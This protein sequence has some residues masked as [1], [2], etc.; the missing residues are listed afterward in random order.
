VALVAALLVLVGPASAAALAVPNVAPLA[1][2]VPTGNNWSLQPAPSFH[3]VFGYS[4]AAVTF[5]L[6]GGDGV[7]FGGRSPSGTT[8]GTTWVNDG[9]FPGYWA[10]TTST[11]RNAP[12]PLTN[13][14]IVYDGSDGYFVMFG[15]QFANGTYSD[16]TWELIGLGQWV[17]V[18]SYQ[19]Q[20]PPAQADAGFAYDQA[21]GV[22]VLLS[23]VGNGST[24]TFHAGNWSLAA[25]P[26]AP[27]VRSGEAMLYDPLDKAVVLF[28]GISH[29]QP[30]NDTWE[31]T[32]SGWQLL[33]LAENPPASVTPRAAY[34]PHHPG[35][36][37]YLGDQT[38]ST[39]EFAGEQWSAVAAVGADTPA[40]RIGAQLYFDSIVDHDILFGGLSIPNGTP[41][42]EDWGWSVPPAPLVTTLTL[43]GL[44]PAEIGGLAAIVA[45]PIVVAWLLRRRPPR[46][47]PVDAPRAAPG[48]AAPA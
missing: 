16:E 40:P 4:Y 47:L 22:T 18:T 1:V 27:S 15:G 31:Y 30:R 5:Y 24:W 45:I 3:T 42:T 11:V 33:S 23:G 39:W 29:G 38:L 26:V 36:L 35:I 32:G 17:D 43:A 9:D 8:L 21:D 41:I 28:G 25:A 48:T 2:A 19:R 46:R 44:S 12:P 10:N 13:A 20:S 14:S 6:P 37:L 7:V 34:D